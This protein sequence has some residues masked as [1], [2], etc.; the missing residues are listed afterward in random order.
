[1]AYEEYV[2]LTA[3]PLSANPATWLRMNDDIDFNPEPANI[4]LRVPEL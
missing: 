2:S 1:M 3:E 4:S